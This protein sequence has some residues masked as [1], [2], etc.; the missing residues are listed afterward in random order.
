MLHN[1][2]WSFYGKISKTHV[3][4]PYEGSHTGHLWSAYSCDFLVSSSM[5]CS[6]TQSHASALSMSCPQEMFKS[7][8]KLCPHKP[9]SKKSC[10]EGSRIRKRKRM[11]MCCEAEVIYFNINVSKTGNPVIYFPRIPCRDV[12]VKEYNLVWKFYLINFPISL[13]KISPI[14]ML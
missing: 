1:T 4:F 3:W 5:L 7:G 13:F 6:E 10:L 11:Q 9:P 14:M 12:H 2:A 8:N